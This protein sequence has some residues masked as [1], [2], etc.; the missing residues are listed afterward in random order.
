MAHVGALGLLYEVRSQGTPGQVDPAI[1]WRGHCR[2]RK[3]IDR[4]AADGQGQ[5]EPRTARLA[6]THEQ[7]DRW[8]LHQRRRQLEG[9]RQV[10]GLPRREFHHLRQPREGATG[11]AEVRLQGQAQGIGLGVV[12]A[13]THRHPLADIGE[14][15][16]GHCLAGE[17]GRHRRRFRLAG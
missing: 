5:V 14:G 17:A 13:Q 3:G 15:R 2:H 7:A 12:E 6:C 4:L 1:E 8:T 11:M 16:Q 9:Q 10:T